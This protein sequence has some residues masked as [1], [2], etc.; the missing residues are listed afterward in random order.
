M[1]NMELYSPIV[2]CGPIIQMSLEWPPG[3]IFYFLILNNIV[4]IELNFEHNNNE[5]AIFESNF[6]W[7]ASNFK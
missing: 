2:L 6:L 4:L 7:I 5:N 3:V 1:Q